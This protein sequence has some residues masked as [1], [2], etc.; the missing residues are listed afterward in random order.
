PPASLVGV[1]GPPWDLCCQLSPSLGRGWRVPPVFCR[2]LADSVCLRLPHG[3]LSRPFPPLS[4]RA[5]TGVPLGPPDPR[6][7]LQ[8]RPSRRIRP[9]LTSLTCHLGPTPSL[10]SAEVLFATVC[11]SCCNHGP[12]PGELENS[13]EGGIRRQRAASSRLWACCAA[14]TLRPLDSIPLSTALLG[15]TSDTMST[16]LAQRLARKTSKQVFVSYNLPNTS[17][18]FEL[19]VENRIREEMQAFPEKF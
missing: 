14:P 17:S 18:S 7:L 10:P 16:G 2:L 11:Q 15:D 13:R 1:S 8:G 6:P 9:L 5:V 12:Q 4:H 19:L 3:P